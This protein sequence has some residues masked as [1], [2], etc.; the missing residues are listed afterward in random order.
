MMV[1]ITR[2]HKITVNLLAEF[3]RQD[4]RFLSGDGAIGLGV[5][6]GVLEANGLS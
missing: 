1:K 4:G 5:G 6:G 2:S 3:S